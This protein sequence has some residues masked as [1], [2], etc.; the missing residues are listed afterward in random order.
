MDRVSENFY[1]LNYLRKSY[2]DIVI[3]YFDSRQ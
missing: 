2:V 1:G 3:K